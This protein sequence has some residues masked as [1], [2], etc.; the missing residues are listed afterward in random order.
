ML[1]AVLDTSVF[2]A[3]FKT[4]RTDV[5]SAPAAVLRAWR[6]GRFTLVTSP[7]LLRELA[8]VLSRHPIPMP[9]IDALFFAIQRVALQIPGHYQ[10]T[11]LDKIDPK[12]NAFL[13]AAYEAKADYLVSL[14]ARHILPVKHF[15]RTQIVRPD[16]FLRF[17][18]RYEDETR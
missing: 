4:P 2:V 13:A 1:K 12:D 18:N 11:R 16:L 8:G 7:E 9:V 14:D 3:A 15:H 5:E 17:L 10:A 6:Q